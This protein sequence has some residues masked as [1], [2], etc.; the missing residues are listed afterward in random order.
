MLKPTFS[1]TE[2]ICWGKERNSGL[3]GTVVRKKI[4]GKH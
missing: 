2:N 3:G 1:T 4:N